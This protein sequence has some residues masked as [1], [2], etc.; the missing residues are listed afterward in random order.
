MGRERAHARLQSGEIRE[1]VVYRKSAL[2]VGLG[3]AS[4]GKNIVIC[5]DGTGNQVEGNLSNVLKLFRILQKNADQ[6]VYYNPGVGTLATDDPWSR[7]KENLIG[8][9][10]RPGRRKSRCLPVSCR[11]P[12][13][14][15]QHLSVWVQ[16]RRLYGSRAGGLDQ[17][18]RLAA[19]R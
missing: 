12:S 17:Y 19:A 10:L 1:K 14:R 8:D 3:W 7:L 2:A 5:C 16:P 9:R 4:M 13:R 11:K 15:R 6:R 18:G